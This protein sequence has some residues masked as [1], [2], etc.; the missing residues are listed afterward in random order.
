MVDTSREAGETPMQDQIDGFWDT[1]K[2]HTVGIGLDIRRELG[3]G[4]VYHDGSRFN[5]AFSKALLSE[6]D[7]LRAELASLKKE[8]DKAIAPFAKLAAEIEHMASTMPADD[9]A[10]SPDGWSKSCSWEDLVAARAFTE[11]WGE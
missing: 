9:P 5:Y 6:R 8:A 11:K 1:L 7:A 10:R 4:T 2:N 3:D